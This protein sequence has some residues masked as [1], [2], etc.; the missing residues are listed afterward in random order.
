[1]MV[2]IKFKI[3][4]SSSPGRDLGDGSWSGVGGCREGPP[5]GVRLKPLTENLLFLRM[6]K[7]FYPRL[8]FSV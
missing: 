8:Y 6:I 1:M 7:L 2:Q 5:H 3:L 4:K